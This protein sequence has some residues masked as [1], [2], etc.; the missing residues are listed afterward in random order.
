MKNFIYLFLLVVGITSQ[1]CD[2]VNGPYTDGVIDTSTVDSATRKVLLED[3]TGFKCVNCPKAHKQADSLL[4]EFGSR[5]VVMSLHVSRTFANP[6]PYSAQHPTSFLYDFRTPTGNEIA[7][8]FNIIDLATG[9]LAS[10]VGL[11]IG[12]VNRTPNSAG[13]TRITYGNWE[14]A[15]SD[16]L[17]ETAKAAVSIT[18]TYDSLSR[19]VSATIS[20]RATE[21][22]T[23]P[24]SISLYLVEDSIVYWQ[25]NGAVYDSLYLHKHVFRGA[26]SPTFGVS[27]GAIAKGATVVKSFNGALP[28]P[29]MLANRVY[30]VAV[31]ADGTTYKVLQVEE[32]KLTQ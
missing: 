31:L 7:A 27:V 20:I 30:L 23:D 6:G 4:K 22:I 13:D 1:G 18:S 28:K 29:E 11:P 10:G 32:K 9:D 17:A 24:A 16:Q 5:L 14:S 26:L 8:Q 2:Y 3:F 15:I 19:N 12:L 21:D 25:E